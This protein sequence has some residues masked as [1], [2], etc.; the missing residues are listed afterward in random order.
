MKEGL[1]ADKEAIKIRIKD[2]IKKAQI[3][4]AF[5]I[6]E[7][8]AEHFGASKEDIHL[9][10]SKY[11]NAVKDNGLGLTERK[12]LDKIYSNT[13]RNIQLIIGEKQTKKIITDNKFW[14]FGVLALLLISSSLLFFN[15]KH[16]FIDNNGDKIETITLDK[17]KIEESFSKLKDPAVGL[18]EKDELIKKILKGGW[19]DTNVEIRGAN[20]TLIKKYEMSIFLKQLKFGSYDEYAVESINYETIIVKR[21]N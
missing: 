7:D 5:D 13:V 19:I 14:V 6:L 2:C 15:R 16:I 3:E 12:E 17:D 11:V 1:K 9:I 4:K 10:R 8:S 21:I 18:K 20:D